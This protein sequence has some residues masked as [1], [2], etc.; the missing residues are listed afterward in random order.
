M[1]TAHNIRYYFFYLSAFV[2]IT[3]GLRAASEI[4]VIL[5]LSIILASVLSPV[6]IF[7][8]KT[9]IPKI[10]SFIF[11]LFIVL[12]L[13]FIVFYIVNTSFKDFILNLPSYETKIKK[14]IISVIGYFDSYGFDI[15]PKRILESF[16]ISS[17][18]KLTTKTI[19]NIGIFLS[20][21]LFVLIGTSFILFEAPVFGKKL[22]IIFKENKEALN[23]F[24]LFSKTVKKYFII[25]L[26]TS[27]LTGFL[28][29]AVLLYFDIS[30]PILWGFLGFLLNFIPVIGSII[31]SLP[32]I[33]L[34]VLNHDIG[35]SLWLIGCYLVINNLISNIIEPKLMGQGL[36]L[37]PAVVFFSLIFWG[38]VLGAVGMFLAVV[39]TMTIK[40]AFDSST[41]TRW[42]G[43]LLS[44]LSKSKTTL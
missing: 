16:D 15:D 32:A 26:F 4:I 34:S 7:L 25:K 41:K 11:I 22:S 19:G 44:D 36:G 10:I 3:A 39:L 9:G 6:M 31:A 1:F 38:W 18:F 24:T 30:Y 14:L 23:S 40:I 2:I 20:K 42:I 5:L 8:K 17:L 13:F 21:T 29:I 35:V 27:L 33:M 43:I 28:I 37:S 12:I